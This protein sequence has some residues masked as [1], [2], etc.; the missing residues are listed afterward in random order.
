MVRSGKITV[1]VRSRVAHVDLIHAISDQIASLVGFDGDEKMNM[2][3]AVRE[4]AINAIKHGNQM[5]P[6]K[7]LRVVFEF[8]DGGMSVAIRDR[9]DGFELGNVADPTLPE[10]LFRTSGRGLLLMKSFVDRVEVR[11]TSDKGTEV[12]LVKLV[13]VSSAGGR[14][15]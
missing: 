12:R 3:L 5:D 9:G 2:G 11:R 13:H 15:G 4:A 10:N 8:D 1:S 14:R 6:R 7:P